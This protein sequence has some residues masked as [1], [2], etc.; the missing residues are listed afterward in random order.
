MKRSFKRK[1][2]TGKKKKN[3]Q[4]FLVQV[5]LVIMI[6]MRFNHSASRSHKEG[7]GTV[8]PTCWLNVKHPLTASETVRHPVKPLESWG[9]LN[10]TQLGIPAHLYSQTHSRKETHTC[11]SQTHTHTHVPIISRCKQEQEVCEV[12][13]SVAGARIERTR[14]RW[15][16]NWF[17]KKI[18]D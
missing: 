8:F 13:H 3:S 15:A 1:K 17:M 4:I 12:G 11:K 9:R 5:R 16:L 7:E 14:Q 18:S 10:K 6:E 2:E